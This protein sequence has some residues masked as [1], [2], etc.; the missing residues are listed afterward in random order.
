[1]ALS[2]QRSPFKAGISVGLNR[3]QVDGDKQS[4]YNKSGLNLALRAGIIVSKTFEVRTE[5]LYNFKG[6]QPKGNELTAERMMKLS[7]Y[8]AEVPLL[9]KFYFKK[10]PEGFYMY[11]IYTGFSYGRL[12]RSKMDL[13]R[14]DGRVDTFQLNK[15]NSFGFKSNDISFIIGASIY[16]SPQLGISFRHSTALNNFYRNPNPESILPTSPLS[17]RFPIRD[18][19]YFKNYFLSFNIFYDFIGPKTKMNKQKHERIK[20]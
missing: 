12:L 15:I 5:L 16:V 13:H 1:M 2:A 4:G 9:A 20:F 18:Y 3:S 8:Y 10:R 17:S 14:R 19:Q 7:L 6:S 11:D